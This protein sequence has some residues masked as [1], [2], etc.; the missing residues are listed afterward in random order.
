M[1]TLLYG[2]SLVHMKESA[3]NAWPADV[4][5]NTLLEFYDTLE[6]IVIRDCSSGG[7]GMPLISPGELDTV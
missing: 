4:P 2:Y 5:L 6:R 1:K 7:L 3:G